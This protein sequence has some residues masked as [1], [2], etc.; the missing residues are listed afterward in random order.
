MSRTK[1]FL[2]LKL[3]VHNV[4]LR[5]WKFKGVMFLS[6]K[7]IPDCTRRRSADYFCKI[8]VGS[9]LITPLTPGFDTQ[10]FSS[11]KRTLVWKSFHLR[12][13]N[14]TPYFYVAA[15]TGTHLL[16]VRKGQL[17]H[18][19]WQPKMWISWKIEYHWQ[20]HCLLT[21]NSTK[22]VPFTCEHHKIALWYIQICK[23]LICIKILR[24]FRN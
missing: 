5:L 20:A 23:I 18:M 8:L 15:T 13:K 22:I 21:V 9:R 12:R 24:I 10:G 16:D 4:S 2:M 14:K 6:T 3:V 11:V 19:R 1:N 17:H 7:T